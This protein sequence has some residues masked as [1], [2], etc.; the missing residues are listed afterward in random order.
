MFCSN[1]GE[2]LEEGSNFCPSCGKSLVCSKA[3][4]GFPDRGR[5]LKFEEDYTDEE[6]VDE[7]EERD[8][9]SFSYGGFWKRLLAYIIDAIVLFVFFL[10]INAIAF[11]AGLEGYL[12]GDFFIGNLFDIVVVWLYYALMESSTEQA[13]LGKIALGMVV[14]DEKGKRIT[15]GRASGRYFGKI[16]STLALFMGFVIIGFTGKKQGLHD[17]FARTLVI[18][19]D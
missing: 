9:A 8:P 19:K 10:I 13:T 5:G 14:V 6:K 4:V 18:N 17:L 7:G 15:F 16:I 11:F 1:C 12:Q 2:K 3:P